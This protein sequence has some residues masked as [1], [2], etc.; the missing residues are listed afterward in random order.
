MDAHM[1]QSATFIALIGLVTPDAHAQS[2]AHRDYITSASAGHVVGARVFDLIAADL[3][4][5]GD[6]DVA[7]ANGSNSGITI[8]LN[9]GDGGF[10]SSHRVDFGTGAFSFDVLDFDGDG[11]LDIFLQAEP[12]SGLPFLGLLKNRGDAT[13]EPISEPIQYLFSHN[14]DIRS[15]DIDGDADQDLIIGN[16]GANSVGVSINLGNGSFANPV[17]YYAS[18]LG[19][20]LGRGLLPADINGD[21]SADIVFW[22]HGQP[23]NTGRGIAYLPNRGD[24]VLLDPVLISEVGAE[25]VQSVD[26]DQDGDLDLVYQPTVNRFQVRQLLNDGSGSFTQGVNISAG[27]DVRGMLNVDLDGNGTEDVIVTSWDQHKIGVAMRS[28]SGEVLPFRFIDTVGNQPNLLMGADLNTDGDI[29]IVASIAEPSSI[30][31]YH[32]G[33][34]TCPSDL[35]MDG[36][37]NFF[38]LSA[39]LRD[40]ID[41][42]PDGFFNLTD[43][44]AFLSDYDQG[45]P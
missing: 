13:F 4:N 10:G 44:L 37:L 43:V 42:F 34:P 22:S 14:L 29:D 18:V 28:C 40:R 20:S 16:F 5:D 3:D 30:E 12:F 21:G 2:C 17:G 27:M 7:T 1:I 26:V 25:L 39:L 8:F 19:T 31:F 33:H 32:N 24:G 35:N 36:S 6:L 41:Y 45:C 23:H 38:D 15:T 11:D 9:D